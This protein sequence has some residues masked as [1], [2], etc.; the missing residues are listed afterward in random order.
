MALRD[1]RQSTWRK[2]YGVL[3][4]LGTDWSPSGSRKLLGELKVADIALRD[5][6]VLG[7]SRS[8]VPSLAVQ[9]K[10]AWAAAEAERA[11]DLLIVD[12]VTRNRAGTLHPFSG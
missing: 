3:V 12:M 4:P 5:P 1:V 7:Q 11:L 2:A 10:P 8:L 6:N 9:G